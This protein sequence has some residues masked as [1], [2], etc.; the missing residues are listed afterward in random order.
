M[1]NVWVRCFS[2]FLREPFFKSRQNPRVDFFLRQEKTWKDSKRRFSIYCSGVLCSMDCLQLLFIPIEEAVSW[3]WCFLTRKIRP[4]N[5]S[6]FMTSKFESKCLQKFYISSKH[7]KECYMKTT[8][9]LEEPNR[10]FCQHFMRRTTQ[11][12]FSAINLASQ[13]KTTKL[14]FSSQVRKQFKLLAVPF[15]SLRCCLRSDKLVNCHVWKFC[16]DLFLN[17]RVIWSVN[18][19]VLFN[20]FLSDFVR[21]HFV[22]YIKTIILFIHSYYA[23]ALLPQRLGFFDFVNITVLSVL[24]QQ[25]VLI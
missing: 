7:E 9:Y 17:F 16:K 20:V 19:I 25:S 12:T 4:R 13:Q 2:H 14:F 11:Q 22:W 21:D 1:H 8:S 18:Q 15:K 3:T 6:F 23:N 5:R 24:R 10:H